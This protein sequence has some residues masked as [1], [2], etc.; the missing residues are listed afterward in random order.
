QDG[1]PGVADREDLDG[2]VDLHVGEPGVAEQLRHPPADLRVGAVAGEDHREDLADPVDGR[3][4]RVDQVVLAVG[5][6]GRDLPAGPGEAHRL[7]D[8]VLRAGHGD[9]QLAGVNQVEGV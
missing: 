9:Q 3:V 6:E 1:A 5:F 8:D 4:G 7:C 2:G